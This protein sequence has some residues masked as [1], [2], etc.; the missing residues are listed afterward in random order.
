MARHILRGLGVLALTL[1]CAVGSAKAA[2]DPLVVI[3]S[4]QS[5]LS[6]IGSRQLRQIF[7]GDSAATQS[8]RVVPFN[9]NPG[10]AERTLFDQLVLQMTPEQ[11]GRYWIDQRIR[12]IIHPPRAVPSSALLQ[13]V[14]AKVD[15]AIGYVHRS[16]LSDDVKALTVDGK[17]VTDPGYPLA[18][19]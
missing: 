5:P 8:A 6:D 12:G 3:V 4:K 1:A 2:D 13:K 11:A 16:E 18:G 15:N 14:V 7:L 19:R 10:S 17:Q 9:L